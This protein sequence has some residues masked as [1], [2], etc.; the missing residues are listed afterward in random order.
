MK[1]NSF[2]I[3]PEKVKNL[4][5]GESINFN[6]VMTTTKKDSFGLRRNVIPI[7]VKGGAT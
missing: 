2:N 1:L 3:E 5:P 4:P 6:V 7:E